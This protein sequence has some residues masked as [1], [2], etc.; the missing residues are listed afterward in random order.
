MIIISYNDNQRFNHCSV[1]TESQAAAVAATKKKARIRRV[2]LGW[3]VDWIEAQTVT[4]AINELPGDLDAAKE[5]ASVHGG[6]VHVYSC[7]SLE[8][9]HGLAHESAT[10][11]AGFAAVKPN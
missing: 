9:A 6:V 3:R 8:D 10:K 4:W 1:R 2:E 11:S 5:H 7:L